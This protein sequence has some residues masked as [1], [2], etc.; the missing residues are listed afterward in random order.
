MY[1]TK[2]FN[3]GLALMLFCIIL[4][5]CGPSPEE[6]AATSVAETA[7][8]ATNTPSPTSTSPP[9]ST[10]K[11][12]PTPTKVPSL[13]EEELVYANA[14]IGLAD[15]YTREWINVF[16]LLLAYEENPSLLYS[17]DW[18]DQ[19][20]AALNSIYDADQ[21]ISQLSVPIR[22]A[23]VQD[24]L[25][26]V[27]S[28]NSFATMML[29][30]LVSERLNQIII[31]PGWTEDMIGYA[32]DPIASSILTI[33]TGQENLE[34][35][36]QTLLGVSSSNITNDDSSD[37]RAR[38]SPDGSR[39]AFMSDRNGNFDIYLMEADGKNPQQLTDHPAIRLQ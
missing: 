3:I 8:A 16:S 10:P 4:S 37:A 29:S 5:A 22:F 32:A 25:D 7:A 38:W 13:S 14:V 34:K 20:A 1:L 39:I 19:L 11:P 24:L 33:Y 18:L 2:K 12:T 6:L 21:L 27:S 30:G 9:T 15:T 35:I 31:M 17:N 28:N 23:E 36:I 26:E